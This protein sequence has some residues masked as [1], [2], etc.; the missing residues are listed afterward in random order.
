VWAKELGRDSLWEAIKARR[1]YALT[2][3][4]IVLKFAVNDQPMGSILP[5]AEERRIEVS[6]VGGGT[7]DYVELLHNNCPIHRWSPIACAAYD[8]TEPVK[9][10]LEVG[11][12]EKDVEVDWQVELE[13]VSGELLAAE[14][15][16][17]GRDVVAPQASEPE[18]YVFS[19]WERMG[20]NRVRFRTR[21][22]GNPTTVTPGTQ[23]MCLEI[24][25]HDNTQIH[26]RINNLAVLVGLENL[27][28]DSEVGYL[29]DRYLAPAYCFHRAVSK[30]EYT[31]Y[32]SLF[33]Q[34]SGTQR[35]WYY[36]RVRQKNGQWAY[37]SPI[38]VDAR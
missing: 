1:T 9:V 30:S 34:E 24:R 5:A 23:G 28:Q 29:G 18:R 27:R 6:V 13:I 16:F 14:P 20:N 10:W 22:W 37:S 31:S 7:L 21:T 12:G 4:Q 36:V 38:W 15:P 35:D 2:G 8:T 17:R 26:A 25:G 33:H 3:D 19:H 11:W 32:A